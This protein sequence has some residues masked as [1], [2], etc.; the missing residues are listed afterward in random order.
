MTKD[1]FGVPG[2]LAD[3]TLPD[4]FYALLGRIIVVEASIERLVTLLH[5]RA[6]SSPVNRYIAHDN[7]SL[8]N[9]TKTAVESLQ[10]TLSAAGGNKP[11]E[12][13]LLLVM[14]FL[15]QAHDTLENRNAY[16]HSTWLS[17]AYNPGSFVGLRYP[18]KD[19]NKGRPPGQVTP[20]LVQHHARRLADLESDLAV[21]IEVDASGRRAYEL[22]ES[23]GIRLIEVAK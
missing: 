14:D 15:N 20:T 10:T 17:D 6:T 5:Q 12:A 22:W 11:V 4:D 9:Q 21:L 16:V 3:G 18:T 23:T 19:P 1:R 2:Y 13:V 8:I 7:R